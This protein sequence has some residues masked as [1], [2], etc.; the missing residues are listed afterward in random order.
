MPANMEVSPD[1]LAMLN[2]L[3][4]DLNTTHDLDILLNRILNE[5]C[6]LVQ[7]EAGSVFL[8]QDDRLQFCYVKNDR[9]FS[10]S[11]HIT[12]YVGE[13]IPLDKSSLAGFVALTGQTLAIDDV[14]QIPPEESYSF[15]RSFDRTSGYRT[16]SMLVVPLIT[17]RG[18]VVGVLETINALDG[19]GEVRPFTENERLWVEFYAHHA[20]MAVERAQITR[21]L[22]LRMIRIAELRDPTET[23]VHVNRVGGYAA[24]IYGGWARARGVAASDVK[25]RK[26]LIRVAA[27]LHDVGKV[28]VSDTILKK[29]G[30]LDRDEFRAMQY[31][32]VA[33]AKLFPHIR[34]ELDA[35]ARDIALN[36]HER[37]DGKGYPGRLDDLSGQWQGPGPG[38]KGEEIP[39]EARITGLADVYDA[40]I[41]PRAY[42]D[43]WPEDKVLDLIREERG[44]HFDPQVVDAFFSVYDRIQLVRVRFSE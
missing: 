9:L 5:A 15:N 41:S 32:T 40:L 23:G 42:K 38:K 27:M 24:E 3:S 33:G 26:D 21:E 28:A 25:K 8:L 11:E 13:E 36:H 35:M 1:L 10:D 31:H 17:S 2:A 14:Y 4:G 19:Q 34:S 39:L 44:R 18:G 12:Q 6:E 16:K 30:R 29:P 20:A 43:P 22:I 7:A 37:W